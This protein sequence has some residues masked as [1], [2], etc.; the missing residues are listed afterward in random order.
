R[1]LGMELDSVAAPLPVLERGDRRVVGRGR[2]AEAGRAGQDAVAVAGPDALALRRAGEERRLRDDVD[3]RAAVF[4]LAGRFDAAVEDE[5]GLRG[6]RHHGRSSE[7]ETKRTSGAMFR[8]LLANSPMKPALQTS[9]SARRTEVTKSVRFRS[10]MKG[11]SGAKPRG[12]RL[13]E[14]PSIGSFDLRSAFQ[15]LPPFAMA[16]RRRA[17][18]TLS[19]CQMPA[20]ANDWPGCR[21]R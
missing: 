8:Q 1:H 5:D 4:A 20:A 12:G 11:W 16:S 13:S 6:S 18:A 9:R 15:S 14:P 17:S 2:G 21:C 10:S 19:G 7:R 3:L